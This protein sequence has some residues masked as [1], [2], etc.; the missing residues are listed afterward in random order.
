MYR[1]T[2]ALLIAVSL[3]WPVPAGG[4]LAGHWKVAIFEGDKEFTLWLLTLEETSGKLVGKVEPNVS[5]PPA[6]VVNLK[7]S[8]G[9]LSFTFQLETQQLSFEVKVPREET[10]ILRGAVTRGKLVNPV[11]LERTKANSFDDKMTL[12]KETLE[13]HPGTPRA[14]RAALELVSEAVNKE[15]PLE[16]VRG[17][18]N[19]AF[20]TAEAFGPTWQRYAT[21]HMAEALVGRKAYGELALKVVQKAEELLPTGDTD[22]QMRVLEAL[23]EAYK[24]LN[25]EADHNKTRHRLEQMELKAYEEYIKKPSGIKLEPFQG[26]KGKSKRAVL[27]ELFTG[28]QCPP[29]VAADLGFDALQKTFLNTD[30][31]L[32]QYHLHIPRQDALTNADSEARQDYY[33]E[34][35]RGTPTI[36]FDGEPKAPGGG[37]RDDAQAKYSEYVSVIQARLEKPAQAQLEGKAVRKGDKV[38][39]QVKVS[40]VDKPGGKVRLRLALVEEWVRYLGGNGLAYHHRVV[41]AFPGGPNGFALTEKTLEKS[42]EID[43]NELRQNLRKYLDN[44]VTELGPFPDQQRPMAFRNLSVVAFVQDDSTREIWQAVEIPVKE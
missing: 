16:E 11:Q 26:R 36:F 41:R 9:L 37:G 27:V 2:L 14:A 10:Q 13:R 33:A 7:L 28:A 43:L 30:V 34:K 31:V 42:V 38:A 1:F 35:L 20:K 40:E 8:D 6:A 4:K 3:A 5:V 21:L 23:A 44:V 15:A 24:A 29:C 12:H 25:R 17:W 19:Q 22:G 39:I 18:A 32:L